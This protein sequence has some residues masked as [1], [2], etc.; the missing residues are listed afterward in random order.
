M[1]LIYL[2]YDTG[3]PED[4]YQGILGISHSDPTPQVEAINNAIAAAYKQMREV[5]KKYDSMP[6][7]IEAYEIKFQ[8]TGLRPYGDPKYGVYTPEEQEELDRVKAILDETYSKIGM[9][10]KRIIEELIET[11]G[12]NKLGKDFLYDATRFKESPEQYSVSSE[13]IS[14]Y[15]VYG[16]AE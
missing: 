14:G 3:Y 15:P 11:I 7:V 12:T 9:E 8:I 6:A 4:E 13:Y 2:N 1:H 16:E 10:R 5:S